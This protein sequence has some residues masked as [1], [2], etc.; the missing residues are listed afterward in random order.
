MYRLSPGDHFRLA[1]YGSYGGFFEDTSEDME[2]EREAKEAHDAENERR[3]AEGLPS[4]EQE[5]AQAEHDAWA[6]T[7]DNG[8][9][10]EEKGWWASLPPAAAAGIGIG[11]GLVGLLLLV[12]IFR[13]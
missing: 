8:N 10:E 5:V 7:Q 6:A 11:G 12:A 13:R 4:I 2:R 3:A 1:T 9:G